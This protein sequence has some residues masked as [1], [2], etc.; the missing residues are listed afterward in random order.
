M[1]KREVVGIVFVLVIF[2]FAF[3]VIAAGTSEGGD[4]NRTNENNSTD[5]DDETEDGSTDVNS[6]SDDDLNDTEDDND[7]E[8]E[9]DDD[10]NETDDDN[11]FESNVDRK[12]GKYSGKNC[13]NFEKRKDRIKCRIVQEEIILLEMRVC[14]KHAYYRMI[15]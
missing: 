10:R 9:T 6:T 3:K 12:S 11:G 4:V 14:L 1:K 15:H 13:D 5:D 2:I 8:N 7:Y